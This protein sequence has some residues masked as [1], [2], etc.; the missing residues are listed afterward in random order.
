[1]EGTNPKD[2]ELKGFTGLY[3]GELGKETLSIFTLQL[4]CRWSAK[5]TLYLTNMRIIF[6]ADQEEALSGKL[7]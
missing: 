1:M 2:G 6:V 7:F 3:D 5:G 4:F